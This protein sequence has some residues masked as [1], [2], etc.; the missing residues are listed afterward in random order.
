METAAIAS[1]EK[2]LKNHVEK[3]V[4]EAS[5]PLATAAA[6]EI[7]AIIASRLILGQVQVTLANQESI[8]KLPVTKT[9]GDC[10][11]MVRVTANS[12][13]RTVR[14]I[15]NPLRAK[16]ERDRSPGGGCKSPCWQGRLQ[17]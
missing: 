13:K 9:S 3:G 7:V 8:W 15:L 1:S 11:Q 12:E 17:L 6:V 5:G 16:V 4:S 2:Y 10:S 14:H